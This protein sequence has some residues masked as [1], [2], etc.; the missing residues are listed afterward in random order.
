[1]V[2]QF[3]MDQMHWVSEIPLLSVIGPRDSVA[4]G[5]YGPH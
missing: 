4:S 3:N 5:G 1:M 2:Q